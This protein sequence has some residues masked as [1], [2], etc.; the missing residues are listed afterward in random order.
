M[1]DE[2]YRSRRPGSARFD[3]YYKLEVY[4]CARVAWR[5]LPKRYAS[6][7][8]A[9]AAAPASSRVR[10]VRVTERGVFPERQLP[11]AAAEAAFSRWCQA[12]DAIVVAR[13]R[14]SLYDLPD[15]P[16]RDAFDAGE[17]PADVAAAVLDELTDNGG[18]ALSDDD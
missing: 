16:L 5:P 6:E 18:L 15:Y 11:D 8:E 13:L 4:D 17:R 14:L 1:P 12:V 3:P 10:L 2:G 7:A 9:I